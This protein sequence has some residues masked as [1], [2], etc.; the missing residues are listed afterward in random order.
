MQLFI[1]SATT[2]YRGLNHS[3]Q[4]VIFPV[5]WKKWTD[6]KAFCFLNVP[7][8]TSTYHLSHR[9][10]PPILCWLRLLS[11]SVLTDTYSSVCPFLLWWCYSALP[12]GLLGSTTFSFFWPNVGFFSPAR[13]ISHACSFCA[14]P[15][16]RLIPFCPFLTLVFINYSLLSFQSLVWDPRERHHLSCVSLLSAFLKCCSPDNPD[17]L[18]IWLWLC[19]CPGLLFI[20]FISYDDSIS[21]PLTNGCTAVWQWKRFFPFHICNNKA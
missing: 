6:A 4:H 20:L 11:D 7:M 13:S 2:I 19:I 5:F 17:P 3:I 8:P 14:F 1:H 10:L 16:F 12:I 18:S 9:N 21:Q 15:G